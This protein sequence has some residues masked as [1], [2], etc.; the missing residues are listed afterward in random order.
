MHCKLC[1]QTMPNE[2]AEF[3]I[4]AGKPVVCISCSNER[5]VITFMDYS[6]KTAPSLVIVGDNKEQ[7]RMA[8]RAYRRAR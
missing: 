2:R 8:T 4:S 7:V 6:H 5:P 3:L 1:Q